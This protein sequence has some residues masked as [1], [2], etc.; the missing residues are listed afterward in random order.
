M[1]LMASGIAKTYKQPFAYFFSKTAY[2]SSDLKSI[3]FECIDKLTNIVILVDAFITDMG[4][5]FVALSKELGITPEH[6]H[7]EV[8]DK[9]YTIFSTHLIYLKPLEIICMIIIILNSRKT[10]LIGNS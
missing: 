5:N 2:K 7:F 4:F 10:K 8:N 1:V 3:I 9:K 6:S